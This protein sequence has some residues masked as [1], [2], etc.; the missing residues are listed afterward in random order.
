MFFRK[1][2]S[3]F[4]YAAIGALAA[5]L[6]VLG[7]CAGQFTNIAPLP[8]EKFER[9]GRAEGKACGTMLIDGTAWN[10]IPVMLNS[11]VERAYAEALKTVPGATGLIDTTMEEYWI[12]WYIGT[13][14]CT[15]ITGE[16][17]R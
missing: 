2:S 5:A 9:L 11:R 8:P 10:F 7:G 6:A 15:T 17:I 14:R 1:S 3:L 16:A 13:T 4:H 12:W